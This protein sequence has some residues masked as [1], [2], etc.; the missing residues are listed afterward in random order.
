MGGRCHEIAAVRERQGFD[1]EVVVLLVLADE[2]EQFVG[3][4][5]HPSYKAVLAARQ[6][7]VVVYLQNGLNRTRLTLNPVDKARNV[8]SPVH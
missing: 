6:E 3:F 5:S 2:L 4:E 1:G 8:L 7:C